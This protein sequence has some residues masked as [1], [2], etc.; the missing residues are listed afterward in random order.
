M[1]KGVHHVQITIPAGKENTARGFYCGICGFKEIPK[2]LALAK[3]SGFWLEVG[4]TQLHVSVQKGVNRWE[5]NSHICF[6][7]SDL[8]FWRMTFERNGVTA[9]TGEGIPGV[10]RFMLRD[11]FGNRLE[12]LERK[13]G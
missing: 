9:E 13:A 11:P 12:F 2:P 10:Q 8:D 6:E 4:S 3:K 7:C 1:I 5:L